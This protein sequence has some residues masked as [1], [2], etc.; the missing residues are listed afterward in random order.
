MG[1]KDKI[2]AKHAI[3]KKDAKDHSAENADKMEQT[4]DDDK[5]E[6]PVKKALIALG[7]LLAIALIVFAGI[8]IYDMTSAGKTSGVAAT[9]NGEEITCDQINKLYAT[10][11]EELKAT[12]TKEVLLNQTISDVVIKQEIIRRNITIDDAYLNEMIV[13]IKSQFSD[14]DQFNQALKAQSLTYQEFSE[15]LSLKLRLN[16]MLEMDIPELKVNESEI[17]A[18]FNK[19]KA[20]LDTPEQIR[21]SHILVNTSEE[22]EKIIAMLK[23]GADFASLAKNF[24]IDTGSAASGGDLG[25]FSKGAMIPEFENASFGLEL[26]EISAPVKSRFG[27]HIIKVY[28]RKPAKA[29]VL[30]DNMKAL[31]DLN[32][33]NT[34]WDANKEKVNI[35]LENLISKAD[36]KPGKSC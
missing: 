19:N 5:V 12:Y 15:Q 30:D 22:A 6:I 24:S 35:Y 1:I 14:E 32:I 34:K 23:S 36:R 8:K 28:D 31:I 26:G 11:P 4:K 29:A 25:Y 9:V 16:K 13:N 21:A 20:S 3:S 7:I 10:V 17:K 33:F 18:F 27:Y 2:L